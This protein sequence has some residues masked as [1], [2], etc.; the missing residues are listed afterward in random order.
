MPTAV[1]AARQSYADHPMVRLETAPPGPCHAVSLQETLSGTFTACATVILGRCRNAPG[2]S[3]A[4]PSSSSWPVRCPFR[5]ATPEPQPSTP[6]AAPHRGRGGTP[7]LLE[8]QGRRPAFAEGGEPPAY[9]V[10]VPFQRMGGVPSGP[11]LGQQPE[12]VPP[13]PFTG[14][15]RQNQ[16]PAYTWH[17]HFPQFEEPA[18]L[19]H[20]HHQPRR[21]SPCRLCDSPDSTGRL[22]RFHL[23]F[24][25][26]RVDKLPL[27]VS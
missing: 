5:Q 21:C 25:L 4:R 19:S 10:R 24:S 23:G 18:Y 27:I 26:G 7:R 3:A 15:G 11:T 17:I 12:G 8:N 13:L 9:G 1:A 20:T 14:R 22:C 2:Q 16:P 6:P